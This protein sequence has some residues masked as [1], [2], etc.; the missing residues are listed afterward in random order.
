MFRSLFMFMSVSMVGI[1][2]SGCQQ[3]TLGGGKA[4]FA[5]VKETVVAENVASP[6]LIKAAKDISGFWFIDVEGGSKTR[7]LALRDLRKGEG[8]TLIGTAV[9]GLLGATGDI[10]SVMVTHQPDGVAIGFDTP[11]GNRIEAASRAGDAELLGRFIWRDNKGKKDDPI[12][13]VRGEFADIEG[14]KTQNIVKKVK[15]DSRISLVYVGAYDCV[16][17]KYWEAG[18]LPDWEK[19]PQAGQVDFRKV[20]ATSYT[21]THDES[22]WPGELRWIVKATNVQAGTPR[23]I[24]LVDNAV[25]GNERQWGKV[26]PLI[27]M[28]LDARRTMQSQ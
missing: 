8:D 23:F 17:C 16:Y 7:V 6:N 22:F 15:K 19:T 2:L 24:V 4:S 20:M 13:M 28:A 5:S 27:Q 18:A 26:P 9:F 12:I 21:N 25:V 14:K 10:V 11:A 1:L 3:A